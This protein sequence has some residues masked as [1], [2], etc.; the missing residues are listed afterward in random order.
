V[1]NSRWN[2][3][4]RPDSGPS[5]GDPC[6]AAFRP[7]GASKV[8]ICNGRF[9]STQVGWN[10]QIAVIGLNVGCARLGQDPRS[11]SQHLGDMRKKLILVQRE[12]IAGKRECAAWAIGWTLRLER[13]SSIVGLETSGFKSSS[14]TRASTSPRQLQAFWLP[15]IFRNT[16]GPAAFHPQCVDFH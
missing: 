11:L 4:F 15:D 2:G 7:I 5:R 3:G 14:T 1:G 12:R 8:A 16:N 6:R 13:M 9:T 10:A